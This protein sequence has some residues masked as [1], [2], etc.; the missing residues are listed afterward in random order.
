MN[1][2]TIKSTNA[3]KV[4]AEFFKKYK[5]KHSDAFTNFKQA[6]ILA[7]DIVFALTQKDDTYV[8]NDRV[9]MAS[10]TPVNAKDYGANRKEIAKQIVVLGVA[11]E[12]MKLHPFLD[13][14]VY[15]FGTPGKKQVIVGGTFSIINTAYDEQKSEK[16]TLE[17]GQTVDI[18]L[19]AIATPEW[20]RK[21]LPLRYSKNVRDTL[22]YGKSS[23]NDR[24]I[25]THKLVVK[26]GGDFGDLVTF[27][28][29]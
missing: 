7:G 22:R 13:G 3:F 20:G 10:L 24:V 8:L 29:V 5:L 11:N 23:D 28:L 19:P 25:T 12:A 27:K 14:S 4:P 9:F 21:T 26:K 17:T 2:P 1:G 15:A 6:N 16:M 18:Y